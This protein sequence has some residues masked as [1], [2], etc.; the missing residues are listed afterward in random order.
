MIIKS[1]A[2]LWS[3]SAVALIGAVVV[4]AAVYTLTTSSSP[5]RPAAAPPGQ[6]GNLSGTANG[7]GTGK[8]NGNGTS[9]HPLT[10]TGAVSGSLAPGLPRTLT[11]T[12]DNAR[13]QA[14][15]LRSVTAS[16]T[17]VTGG[18]DSTKPP[19]SRDWFSVGSYAGNQPIAKGQKGQVELPLTLTNLPSVNQDNC[20]GA[21]YS[22]AFTATADQA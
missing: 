12:V 20:K 16:I 9:G 18:S 1:A 6:N 13:N 14:V 19:C 7:N 17:S 3:S 5:T 10:V 4:G 22:L 15:N 11:V 2:L 8:G 21:R